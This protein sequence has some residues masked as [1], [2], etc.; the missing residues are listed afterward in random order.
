[1]H[2]LPANYFANIILGRFFQGRGEIGELQ[3]CETSKMATASS[4]PIRVLLGHRSLV[5]PGRCVENVGRQVGI[6]G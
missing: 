4:S 5:C 2:F 6:L 1:M 3:K